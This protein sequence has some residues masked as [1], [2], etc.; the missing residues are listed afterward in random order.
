VPETR[1]PTVEE[2]RLIH[3]VLDP[4]GLREQEVPNP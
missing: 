4:T 1:A 3:E 2:L